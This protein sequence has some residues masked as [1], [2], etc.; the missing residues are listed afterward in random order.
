MLFP[1]TIRLSMRQICDNIILIDPLNEITIRLP[2]LCTRTNSLTQSS[3]LEH[4]QRIR[5]T[6]Q[7]HQRTAAGR[8]HHAGGGERHPQSQ[9]Q[10]SE[11][12]RIEGG[13]GAETKLT[14][15]LLK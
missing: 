6:L 4:N 11:R 14:V 12:T 3:P 1:I 5:L 15:A 10:K 8:P 7:P 9:M 2:Y 13:D